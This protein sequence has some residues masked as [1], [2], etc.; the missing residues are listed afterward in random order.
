VAPLLLLW[1]GR[2][3]LH[4]DGRRFLEA[5]F[6]LACL[7]AIGEIVFGGWLPIR[8]RN[9]PFAFL[10]TPFLV[11]VAYRGGQRATATATFVL[12][13][14]ALLGTL[15]GF[16][17]FALG[18]PN[19]SVLVLQGFT[20]VTAVMAMMLAAAVAE[21]RRGEAARSRLASIVESSHDAIISKTLDGTILSWN[22]AAASLYGYTAE[23]A[24]GRSIS[25]LA[26]RH[27]QDEVPGILERIRRGES[28]EAFETLRRTKDGRMITV[29]LT[30]SPFTDASGRILG[31]SAIARDVTERKRAEEAARR[32][33]ALLSVTR[34]ANAA[35]HEIN[36][37]L[38]AMLVPLEL[39]AREQPEGSESRRRLNL[40]LNSGERIRLIVA[41]MQ[42][43][44]KLEVVDEHADLPERLD[45]LKSAPKGRKEP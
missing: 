12:S 2:P 31:T 29:S 27:R 38:T 28:V 32:A 14:L 21:S 30:I 45:L 7:V 40:A 23:E 25:I 9:H 3:R 5:V 35:A 15:S 11:W 8:L 43:I 36:N 39:L 20:V 4:V 19:E 24:I 41:R 44:M 10:C 33:E 13:G 6:M 1:L 18:T 26:P 34:L 37:P 22:S 16:G 17:P 42:R